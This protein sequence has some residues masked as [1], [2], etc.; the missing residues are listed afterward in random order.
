MTRKT[1]LIVDDE[2]IVRKLVRVALQGFSDA[3]I[4]EAHDAT[5]ALE[6]CNAHRG[7][8]DLLLSDVLMPGELNGAQ[9]AERFYAIHPESRIL[10][11]S[12]YE[13]HDV[14]LDPRWDFIQKPFAATEIRDTIHRVL[15]IEIFG[16]RSLDRNHIY[17]HL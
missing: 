16:A 14:R 1:I 6:I 10:L 9:M 3:D 17:S 12:G 15:G 2:E 4:L 11:M 8:I 13:A 7:P 5:E